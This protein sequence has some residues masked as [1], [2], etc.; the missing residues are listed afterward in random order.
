MSPRLLFLLSAVKARHLPIER[1][2]RVDAQ[3]AAVQTGL[4]QRRDRPCL[5]VIKAPVLATA[6]IDYRPREV[7]V[8][9]Y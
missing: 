7:P 8:G 9:A 2:D 5:P 3:L 6:A 1:H 4:G